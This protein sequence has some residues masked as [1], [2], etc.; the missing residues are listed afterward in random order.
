MDEVQKEQLKKE[1]TQRLAPYMWKPG[2]S[3]NPNGR[4]KE[5]TLKEYVREFLS[6]MTEKE[7]KEYLI[8]MDKHVIWKMA[9]GNPAQDLTSGGEKIKIVPIYSG[10]SINNGIALPEDN[11][12]ESQETTHSGDEA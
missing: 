12:D 10:A 5:K 9:E 3:G 8:G 6:S 4:P 11:Q 7:R 2:Q 1:R